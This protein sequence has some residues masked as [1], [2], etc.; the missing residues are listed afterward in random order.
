MQ[1]SIQYNIVSY[2][3]S[4][5]YKADWI[6]CE[7][8]LEIW[9]K[10]YKT[11]NQTEK[12]YL[13]STMRTPGDDIHLVKGWLLSI[14]L[15]S[16]ND[17]FSIEHTGTDRLKENH[18]NRILITLKP[19]VSVELSKY[20]ANPLSV[21]SC[22]VCGQQNIDKLLENLSPID[23]QNRVSLA[24]KSICDL[25]NNLRLQQPVFFRTGGVHAA[26]LLDH[27]GSLVGTSEDIGRHNALDKLIGKHLALLPGQYAV[28]LS[29]RVSFEMVQKSARAGI[30]MIIAVGA[31]TS[32]AVDL[33]KELDIALIGF[34]KAT[35]FNLYHG[36][37]QLI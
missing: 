36:E 30:S 17:I 1:E 15:V 28:L 2:K 12:L 25:P 13:H 8:P 10:F 9:L 4:A 20:K 34:I 3:N 33:C 31:P 14:D 24:A 26:A 5:T 29:G 35:Q 22:G 11:P 16:L 32:L 21:S 23:E 6:A 27:K 18:S 37:R 19:G 7:Q